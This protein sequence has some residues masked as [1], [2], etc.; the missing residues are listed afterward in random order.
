M[1]RTLETWKFDQNGVDR[2]LDRPAYPEVGKLV[3]FLDTRTELDEFVTAERFPNLELVHIDARTNYPSLLRLVRSFALPGL[4]VSGVGI[5]DLAAFMAAVRG[6]AMRTLSLADVGLHGDSLPAL[7]EL[8][9]LTALETLSLSEA[10]LGAKG[11]ALLGELRLPKLRHLDLDRCGLG[12]AGLRKVARI[13]GLTRLS[14]DANRLKSE[15]LAALAGA[16]SAASIE[17]LSLRDNRGID[18]E[19]LAHLKGLAALRIVDVDGTNI[20]REAAAAFE[21]A[22]GVELIGKEDLRVGEVVAAGPGRSDT[23]E[24]LAEAIEFLHP[25]TILKLLKAGE[26]AWD[27]EYDPYAAEDWTRPFHLI[28]GV[29][30]TKEI[31]KIL[32][33]HGRDVNER[34]AHGRTPLFFACVGPDLRPWNGERSRSGA[35]K[36]L[37][38]LLDLGADVHL[39]DADGRSALHHASHVGAEK[40]VRR[41]LKSG[42]KNVPDKAGTRPSDLARTFNH[43][44][45]IALL[46]RAT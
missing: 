27:G 43:T 32:D 26:L 4:R 38:R 17:R 33:A 30:G 34:D 9:R 12:V 45:L 15:H 3:F 10:K 37:K 41:L 14:L 5:P 7:R 36:T 24:Q 40:C 23:P 39:V 13:P 21:A 35:E 6:E 42:A 25:G 22:R 20:T 28:A 18:D 1:T 16:A 8:G 19:A 44:S 46:E 11:G 2:T 29:G 31:A